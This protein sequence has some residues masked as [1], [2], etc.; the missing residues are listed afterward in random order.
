MYSTERPNRRGGALNFSLKA[1][2][3]CDSVFDITGSVLA[4]KGISL[5]LADLDNTL[6]PYGVARP[7]DRLQVWCRGL[8]EAGVALFVLSNNR[9]SE[10]PRVFCQAMGIPFIGHAGK[11]KTAGFHQAMKQLNVTAR[12]TAIVGD[13]VFTDVLGG[14]RAGVA[15][16][17]V[18]PISL[19]GNPGR[20]LRY[21]A[22]FP[23]RAA[24]SAEGKGFDK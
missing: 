8:K 4:E 2:Y 7:D 16:I 20:F 19:A 5:L 1:D 6:V 18:K 15:T 13:Q 12:Q 22:E 10:R 17:L 23:F 24:S 11:P 21:A 3:V 14:N 9:H